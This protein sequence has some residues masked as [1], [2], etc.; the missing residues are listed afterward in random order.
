MSFSGG[1]PLGC[2]NILSQNIFCYSPSSY[3]SSSQFS[4]S[5]QETPTLK[6]TKDQSSGE[7]VSKY[8]RVGSTMECK[9]NL[10]HQLSKRRE[11]FTNSLKESLA[12]RV[13]GQQQQQTNK[14]K[15]Y[16]LLTHSR[17]KGAY[18]VSS[19]AF[20]LCTVASRDPMKVRKLSLVSQKQ[21]PGL[22]PSCPEPVILRRNVAC[23]FLEAFTFLFQKGKSG[24]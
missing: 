10:R 14:Q 5:K 20:L 16:R 21:F 13:R 18:R 19:P 17:Q 22:Y 3:L 15:V 23:C 12:A 1:L 11:L 2:S 9:A 24:L 6:F 4:R 7:S 8:R